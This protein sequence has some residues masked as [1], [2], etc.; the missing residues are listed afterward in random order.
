MKGKH[1]CTHSNT[2]IKHFSKRC[3]IMSKTMHVFDHSGYKDAV[4]WWSGRWASRG[5]SRRGAA[6]RGS[7][8]DP[9]GEGS[10]SDS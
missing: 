3:P 2:K 5:A 9:R 8:K 4:R 1:V 10:S 7:L 6:A